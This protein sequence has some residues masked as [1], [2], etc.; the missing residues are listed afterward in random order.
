MSKVEQWKD[1]FRSMAK[2]HTPLEKIYK[3]KR[4]WIRKFKKWKKVCIKL[5]NK[6]L[7]WEV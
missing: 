1:H 2:G 3:S 4:T 6:D 5:I 7:E